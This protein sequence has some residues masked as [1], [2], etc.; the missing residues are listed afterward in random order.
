MKRH[1][2]VVNVKN[3]A[4]ERMFSYSHGF[5]DTLTMSADGRDDFLTVVV[6][7]IARLKKLVN[8]RAG[9]CGATR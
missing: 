2:Y 6:K 8:E 9:A 1:D 4:F 3:Y 5:S 7:V